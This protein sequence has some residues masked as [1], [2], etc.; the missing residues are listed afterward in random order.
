MREQESSYFF[1]ALRISG[2]K[3]DQGD[4]ENDEPLAT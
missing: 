1:P 2:P 3:H 4:H